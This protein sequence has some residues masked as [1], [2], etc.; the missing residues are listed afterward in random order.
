M[1]AELPSQLIGKKLGV[2]RWVPFQMMAW[3]IVAML[4]CLIQNRT[5]FYVTRALFGLLEGGFIPD[6]VLMLSYFF[7]TSELAIRLSFFWIA[8]GATTILQALLASGILRL[9]GTHGWAGWRYLFLIEGLMTFAI[10]LFAAGYLPAS[11]TQTKGKLRGKDGWFTEREEIIIVNRILRD[12]PTKSQMH[13]RQGL[14]FVALKKSFMDFDMWP[15]YLLGFTSYVA[16]G[17]VGAYLTLT[18]KGLGFS[19]F[20][21]NMMIIPYATLYLINN[22]AVTWLSRKLNQ[23]ALIGML[24]SVWQFVF[25]LVIV[26]LPDHAN[27]WVRYAFLSLFLAYPYVHPIV[28]SWN[29]ANSGSV[30]TRSV[31]A[32]LYNISVQIGSIISSQIYH[33]KDKPYYHEG[34]R[35]LLYIISTNLLLW[36][37]AKVYYVLRNKSKAAKWD[38]LS[39]A[40]KA[41]YLD[42][43]TDEGNRRLDFRFVH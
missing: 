37:F 34:N 13:N 32:S 4:Q 15:L 19:T 14:S 25:L 7:T 24:G 41:D 2:E 8:N 38:A 9:R 10:G 43:T 3:S 40:E 39:P 5:G 36:V 16:P 21:T 20:A 11:P 18:I 6:A 1:F 30:R 35:V 26:F 17:T 27:H 23:R 28:V 22:F 33:P 29:S 12:D 31:S 42:T